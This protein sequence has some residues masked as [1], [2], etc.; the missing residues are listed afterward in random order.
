[1]LGN[2]GKQRH[3]SAIVNKCSCAHATGDEEPV[4]WWGIQ[5]NIC[6]GDVGHPLDATIGAWD[7]C[8]WVLCF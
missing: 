8:W 5:H 4:D 6:K 7:L 1:M 3:G 2:A